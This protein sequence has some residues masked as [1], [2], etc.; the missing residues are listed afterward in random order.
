VSRRPNVSPS[1]ESIRS[2]GSDHVNS[3]IVNANHGVP[4]GGK[5]DDLAFFSWCRRAIPQEVSPLIKTGFDSQANGKL[6]TSKTGEA[7]EGKK[8]GDA[9]EKKKRDASPVPPRTE[10]YSDGASFWTYRASEGAVTAMI[11]CLI[12]PRSLAALCGGVMCKDD[13]DIS[14]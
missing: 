2:C 3:V 12:R 14:A 9:P 8:S 1:L 5:H 10:D 11:S 13:S 7:S 4:F 6:P